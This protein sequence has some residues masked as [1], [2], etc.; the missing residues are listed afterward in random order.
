[1]PEDVA[2]LRDALIQLRQR[3]DAVEMRLGAIESTQAAPARDYSGEIA[4]LQARV[5]ALESQTAQAADKNVLDA[6]QMRVAAL[7]R[8]NAGT[9]RQ[10]AAQI[11]ALSILARS[12]ETAQPL[13][14]ELDAFA[15][16]S[17]GDPAIAVLMPYAEKAVPTR[18]ELAARFPDAARAALAN[19]RLQSAQGYFAKLWAR[20]LNL[21]SV[22]RTGPETGD[23]VEDRLARAGHDLQTGDLAGAVMEVRA[24]TGPAADTMAP[25]LKDAEARL[26]VDTSIAGLDSRIVHALA[27]PGADTSGTNAAGSAP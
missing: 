1:V 3:L 21:V 27:V 14:P 12:A 11:L 19:T 2:Q 5:S 7:E 16:L 18:S 23:T 4:T 22:R 20:A 9:E 15:A 26:A 25:W 13:K 17:P 24:L 8:E 6:L 10:R